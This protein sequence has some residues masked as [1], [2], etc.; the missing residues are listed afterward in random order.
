[1]LER[2]VCPRSLWLRRLAD[3]EPSP[4][5]SKTVSFLLESIFFI[6]LIEWTR[7]TF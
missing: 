5:Y 7:P 1:M 6:S 3:G 4:C 2:I